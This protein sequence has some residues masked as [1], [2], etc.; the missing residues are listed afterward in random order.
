MATVQRAETVR[1]IQTAMAAS[2]TG[3]GAWFAPPWRSPP[4]LSVPG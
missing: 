4:S 3:L 2:Y 1:R